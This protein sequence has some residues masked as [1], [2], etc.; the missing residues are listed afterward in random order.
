MVHILPPSPSLARYVAYYLAMSEYFETEVHHL[1]SARGAGVLA[2]PFKYP[3]VTSYSFGESDPGYSKGILDT[4]VLVTVNNIY[5]KANFRGEVNFVMVVFQ[6]TGVHHFLQENA[7]SMINGVYSL[8][9]LNLSKHFEELQDRLWGISDPIEAIRLADLYLARYVEQKVKPG[10]NDFTPV[11]NHILRN[12]G[13]LSVRDL[14]KKFNCSE[15][16]IQKQCA[17]QTGLPPKTWI[18]MI[19]FRNVISYFLKHPECTWMEIVARFHYTD[20]SH[21]IKDFHAFT[22]YS[23]SAYFERYAGTERMMRQDI[24]KQGGLSN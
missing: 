6:M 16:W 24:A 17:L 12:E 14:T 23:P 18:R 1:M 10:L 4:P 13:M 8:D 9:Q 15:R 5:S 3:S 2:I 22:G 21:L 7:Q 20:Q 11:A 19:R